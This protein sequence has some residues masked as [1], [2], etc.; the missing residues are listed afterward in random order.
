M[1]D[2]WEANEHPQFGSAT[3]GKFVA[4]ARL[5]S[6]RRIIEVN[7]YATAAAALEAGACTCTSCLEKAGSASFW[8]KT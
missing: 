7:A 2:L 1:I 5:R 6:R 3:L 4:S 8:R